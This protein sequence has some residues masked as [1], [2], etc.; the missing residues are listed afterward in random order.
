[1]DDPYL[2]NQIQNHVH[3]SLAAERKKE[4]DRLA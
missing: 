2:S 3:E 4:R 1:M